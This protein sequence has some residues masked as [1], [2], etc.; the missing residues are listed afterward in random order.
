[1]KEKNTWLSSHSLF[2]VAIIML[3]F[4]YMLCDVFLFKPQYKQHVVELKSKYDSLQIYV[5]QKFPELDSILEIHSKELSEQSK[6]I[7]E[8]NKSIKKYTK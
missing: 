1:M 3:M 4:T 5:D 8:L 6:Q 7:D 2:I